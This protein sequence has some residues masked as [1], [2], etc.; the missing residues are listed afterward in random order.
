LFNKFKNIQAEVLKAFREEIP[1]IYYSDKTKKDFEKW[2]SV[3]EF[4]YH[5]L[6]K[7]PREMFKNKTLIDLGSGTGENTVYFDNWGAKC[8]LVEMNPDAFKISK[9]IF[10][11]YSKNK[12]HSFFNES[13][14]NVKIN[15]KFDFAHSRGVF[16]HTNNPDKA[17]EK[18]ASFVKPGGYLIYGD[19]NKSGNF[20]NMLQRLAIFNF[21]T[22]WDDMVN[23]AEVLFKEDLD[24][25]Q[26]FANRTRRCIIFDKW[27]VPRLT[28]P[29]I[30]EVLTWFKK[31]KISF[32]SSYP[33]IFPAVFGDSLHHRPMFNIENMMTLTSF[34]EAYWLIQNKMDKSE[35]PKIFTGIN[36]LAKSQ[37][38]LVDYIDDY[39]LE[40][41]KKKSFNSL[42]NKLVNYNNSIQRTNFDKYIKLRTKKFCHEVEDFLNILETKNLVKCKK[43]ISKCT[44]LFSGAQGIR[45]IDFIGYKKK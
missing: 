43:Y 33:N 25:S 35:V 28:N 4:H 9:N 14:Y 15:K 45:H 13:I 39:N 32:Y 29:S 7:F 20:Q 40:D 17:F 42:S 19:G 38:D 31:N 21:A 37:N 23:V 26:K 2:K 18:L 41:K 16:A 27:V 22:N 8:T 34:V 12:G 36:E 11:K 44:E 1:S 10:K 6:M 5:D 30:K 24:R 3:M